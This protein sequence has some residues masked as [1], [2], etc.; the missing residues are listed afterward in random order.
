MK[1]QK[2][3]GAAVGAATAATVF[4]LGSTAASADPQV[5]ASASLLTVSGAIS[6]SPSPYAQSVD[7]EPDH[8]ELASIGLIPSLNDSGIAA[9]L[10]AVDAEGHWA[11]AS[12]ARLDILEL[13][14]ADLVKTWCDGD[15]GGLDL[16]GAS[17]LGQPLTA[18]QPGT[19]VDVSPLI[20]VE[21]NKQT[22]RDGTLTVEGLKVTVLPSA[23]N[24][25]ETLTDKEK[26]A[27]P[28]LVGLLGGDASKLPLL[29]TV[30]DLLDA[31]HAGSDSL[32]TVTVG[33]ASCTFDEES[34]EEPADDEHGDPPA[35]SSDEPA[36]EVA[37][38][39]SHREAAPTP[40]IVPLHLPVTG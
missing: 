4:L 39:A 10:L 30:G 26:A 37:V 5:T 35:E 40:T 6:V 25:A 33:T 20:K 29:R 15:E 32:L 21:L 36:E 24:R 7:G 18:T 11:Q 13:V 16:V 38:P 17:I 22:R 14:K 19:T 27:A 31:L 8:Q 12:V 3:A 2:F 34:A 1:T 28:E 23:K 9:S